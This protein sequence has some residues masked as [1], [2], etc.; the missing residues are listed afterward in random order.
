MKA[1]LVDVLQWYADRGTVR[2]ILWVVCLF[3]CL[4]LCLHMTL[5]YSRLLMF[6]LR[7]NNEQD[8]VGESRLRTRC[9]HLANWTK[10]TRRL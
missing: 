5:V 10:H 3:V 8:A 7:S 6:S 4:S 1:D 9:R 2:V